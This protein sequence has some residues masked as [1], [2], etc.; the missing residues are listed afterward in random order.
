MPCSLSNLGAV[1]AARHEQVKGGDGK[2]AAAALAKG[3]ARVVLPHGKR[4]RN[5]LLADVLPQSTVV[6]KHAPPLK[7]RK[8]GTQ[9]ELSP[10]Q[11]KSDM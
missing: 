2:S 6:D 11:A 1:V 9:K 4:G 3:S 8:W 10:A 7:R 5:V